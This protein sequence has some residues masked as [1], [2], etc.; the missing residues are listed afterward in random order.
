MAQTGLRIFRWFILVVCD[1]NISIDKVGK[2]KHNKTLLRYEE[3]RDRHV[4]AL[5]YK[6]IIR[7][8]M[9]NFEV[10]SLAAIFRIIMLFGFT[11]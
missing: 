6:A 7:S 8:D 3:S 11:V 4:S 10:I 5:F 1:Y 9:E 2:S